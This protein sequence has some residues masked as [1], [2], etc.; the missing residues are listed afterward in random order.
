MTKRLC[1]SFLSSVSRTAALT[2]DRRKCLALLPRRRTGGEGVGERGKERV[3]KG[4]REVRVWEVRVWEVR[5]WDVRVW[6]VRERGRVNEK[7]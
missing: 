6:E 1:L 3:E 2:G 5:R 7:D 4:E